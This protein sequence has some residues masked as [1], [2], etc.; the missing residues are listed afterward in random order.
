VKNTS[1]HGSAVV[2]ETGQPT[3]WLC[4]TQPREYV[5]EDGTRWFEI[6]R[7]VSDTPCPVEPIE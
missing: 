7:Y 6:D 5:G 1:A 3:G 2:D 4:E